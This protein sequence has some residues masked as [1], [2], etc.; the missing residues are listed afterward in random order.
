MARYFIRIF[1]ENAKNEGKRLFFQIVGG[2][3]GADIIFGAGY[4][5]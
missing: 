1:L 5:V 3:G 4:F 2:N